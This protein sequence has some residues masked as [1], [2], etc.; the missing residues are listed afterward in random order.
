MNPLLYFP[1]T[2]CYVAPNGREGRRKEEGGREGRVQVREYLMWIE[3][4]CTN[5]LQYLYRNNSKFMLRLPEAIN[6][7]CGP[8][9]KKGEGRN[10]ITIS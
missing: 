8:K 3:E 9:G 6:N 7:P 10:K 1:C 5:A 2:D 4:L